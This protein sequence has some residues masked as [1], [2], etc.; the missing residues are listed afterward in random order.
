MHRRL[1]PL[2]TEMALFGGLVGPYLF[3][4]VVGVPGTPVQ[5]YQEGAHRHSAYCLP[6]ALGL[7][8]VR[9]TRNETGSIFPDAFAF[10]VFYQITM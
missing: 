8:K 4:T 6:S 7:V 2:L 1:S 9:V 5:V 10:L 3:S